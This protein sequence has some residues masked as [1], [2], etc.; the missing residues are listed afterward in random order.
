MF[1][2]K[3]LIL[4]VIIILVGAL[5]FM[6]MMVPGE[7]G[8]ASGGLGADQAPYSGR[9]SHLVGVRHITID[10]QLPLTVWY[11]ASRPDNHESTM[12]YPYELKL[13]ASWRAITL[14]TFAGE[15]ISAAPFEL[16]AAPY[17]LVILSPGFAMGGQTYGWL[18]EHLASY[19]FVVISPEH[20]EQLDPSQ[21]WRA[22]IT[23]PQDVQTVLSFV[24]EQVTIGGLFAGLID[25]NQTAVIGH[26]YGGYTALVAGGARLNTA[27]FEAVCRTAGSDDPIQFLCD[28]LIPRVDDMV[29]LAGLESAPEGL[30]PDWGDERVKAIISMAGDAAVFG[31]AGLAEITV[32][33]M[34]VG[35]TADLDSP[36]IWSTHLAYEFT[37]SERK[38]QI[39]LEGAEHMIFTGRCETVR[40]VMKLVP[41][42]FCS[43]P[44]W[45]KNQAHDLIKHFTAAF[46]LAELKQDTDAAVHLTPD[47]SELFGFTYK[48]GGY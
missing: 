31:P 10:D 20:D 44:A 8:F 22:T 26:S 15:A 17:P 11:P 7:E 45:D 32:P 6:G 3:R 40:R 4:A 14:A 28:A 35:G 41:Y 9:G 19:G 37:S 42:G 33:V 1:Y 21:L 5:W 38:V 46:L 18:A 16:S 36:Y 12:R 34:A 2:L 23:R 43:D 27:D 25:V 29:T 13:F 24:D 48:V 47:V 30:W 39:G